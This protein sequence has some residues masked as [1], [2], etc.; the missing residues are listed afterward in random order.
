M[1]DTVFSTDNEYVQS[2]RPMELGRQPIHDGLYWQLGDSDYVNQARD[3]TQHLVQSGI[4]DMSLSEFQDFVNLDWLRPHGYFSTVLKL[5]RHL[6]E[7]NREV[8]KADEELRW[9]RTNKLRDDDIHEVLSEMGDVLWLQ[10][11]Q[12]T[13]A[14]VDIERQVSFQATSFSGVDNQDLIT[15]N[16]IDDLVA[17]G[18]RPRIGASQTGDFIMNLFFASGFICTGTKITIEEF[19]EKNYATADYVSNKQAEVAG[20]LSYSIGTI[21]TRAHEMGATL[22]DVVS[23]NIQKISLRAENATLEDKE[24]RKAVEI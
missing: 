3:R 16:D 9:S 2:L 1:T 15:I 7:E 12:A 14:G 13:S 24:K 8:S 6:M 4:G 17:S 11:A 23:I 20:W 21:A 10:S 18:Y 22:A 19:N 5:E